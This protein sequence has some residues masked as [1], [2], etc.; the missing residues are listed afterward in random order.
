MKRPIMMFFFL[1]FPFLAAVHAEMQEGAVSLSLGGIRSVSGT[2]NLFANPAVSLLSGGPMITMT[3]MPVYGMED[4]YNSLAA[5]RIPVKKATLLAGFNGFFVTGFYSGLTFA[6]G[7]SF[8]ISDQF[9]SGFTLKYSTVNITSP[10][11][12]GGSAIDADLGASLMINKV[13]SAGLVIKNITGNQVKLSTGAFAPGPRELD[14]GIRLNFMETIGLL[15]EEE[16][17]EGG[18]PVLKIGSELVFY[19]VLFVRAG[20][21]R[22]TMFSI[23]A[24]IRTRHV[25]IDAA[26]KA[27]PDLGA[28]Y[29]L[30]LTLGL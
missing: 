8:R 29:M 6:A 28:L 5:V 1:L 20:L 24:G 25:L 19:N 16:F 3:F 10:G 4:C 12:N 23:G 13:L 11:V 22:N 14:A 18:L 7:S 17:R 26:V 21:D 30:D 9:S 27:H 2:G 15:F